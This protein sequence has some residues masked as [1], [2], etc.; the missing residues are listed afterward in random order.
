ME[1]ND[2]KRTYHKKSR[3]KGVDRTCHY[4]SAMLA[5]L[6]GPHYPEPGRTLV[7]RGSAADKYTVVMD[8]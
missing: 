1:S 2:T 5:L 3:N 8:C 7:E 4:C 6:H